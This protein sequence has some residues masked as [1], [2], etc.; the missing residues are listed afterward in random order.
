MSFLLKPFFSIFLLFHISI[1]LKANTT[2]SN[3]AISPYRITITNRD[4]PEVVVGCDDLGGDTLS[5]GNSFSWRFRMN[6]LST[7][8]YNC[9]FYWLDDKTHEI[10]NYNTFTV[11]NEDFTQPDLCGIDI[12][13]RTTRCYWYVTQNGFYFSKNNGSFPSSEWRMMYGWN[14]I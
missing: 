11:F 12:F 9:R 8:Q 2:P 10:Q 7:N 14:K 5:P 6:L 1:I 3:K 4:I 13:F